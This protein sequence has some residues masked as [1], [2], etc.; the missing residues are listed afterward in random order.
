MELVEVAAH[1]VDRHVEVLRQLGHRDLP[2]S[3]T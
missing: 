2:C 3:A 1:G